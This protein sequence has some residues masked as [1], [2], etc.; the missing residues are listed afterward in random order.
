MTTTGA[1]SRTLDS[2][3]F[4]LNLSRVDLIKLDID[5]FECR[6]M[7][8][9]SDVL[10]RWHPVLVME[11]APYALEEQGASLHELIELLKSHG[12][13]L[14]ELS[15]NRPIVM[16]ADHLTKEIPPGASLN[17]VARVLRH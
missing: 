3:V 4:S 2:V 7:R 16:D 12:Y 1:E 17:V 8:G 5:G 10:T 11:L 15:K 6:M 9:A 14:F 13:A